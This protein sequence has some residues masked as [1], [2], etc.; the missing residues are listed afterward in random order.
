M[1]LYV[2]KHQQAGWRWWYVAL[3]DNQLFKRFGHSGW[4]C[5]R[6][7]WLKRFWNGADP[8]PETSVR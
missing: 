4:I 7:S 2:H 6:A 5:L 8:R 3:G 1:R